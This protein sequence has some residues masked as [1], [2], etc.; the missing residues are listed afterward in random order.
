MTWQLYWPLKGWAFRYERHTDSLPGYTYDVCWL[1]IGPF[2]AYWYAN[3][4][5]AQ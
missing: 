1:F 5:I 4:R 2:Q 3:A